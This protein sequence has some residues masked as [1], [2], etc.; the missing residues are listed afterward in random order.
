MALNTEPTYSTFEQFQLYTQVPAQAADSYTEEMWK[1]FALRAEKILDTYVNIPNCLKFASDQSLKFPIKDD[2]GSSLVPDDVT[3]AAIEITSDLILK[4]SPSASDEMVV[5]SESW[6]GAGYSVSQKEKASSSSSD[7][8]KIQ[9]PPLAR[10]LLMPW[11][12]KVAS[13]KY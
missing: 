8:I 6:D 7:D 5:T 2:D 10:R 11:T 12:N 4:G 9:M 3:L 1:P 13:L